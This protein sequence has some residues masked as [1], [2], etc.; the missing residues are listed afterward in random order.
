MIT[1]RQRILL[2]FMANP[3]EQL[4]VPDVVVKWGVETTMASAVL[5]SMA[6]DDL[7]SRTQ[8]KTRGLPW[9]YFAGPVMKQALGLAA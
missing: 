3:D 4:L 6:K 5:L 2:Y 7:L 9:T 1:L 8:A